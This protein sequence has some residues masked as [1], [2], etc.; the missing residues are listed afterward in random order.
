[1]S[2]FSPAAVAP[3]FSLRGELPIRRLTGALATLEVSPQGAHVTDWTIPGTPPVLFLSPRSVFQRGR[4]IRGG[5]PL[6]FPWFGPKAGDARAAQHGFARVRE[7]QL[8]AA[9]VQSDGACSV[10]M[11]LTD[12]EA[13]RAEWP[14]A[15]HARFA[16]T[17]G[18]ELRMTLEIRSAD[19]RDFTFEAA[20]HT[21]FAV[22]DVRRIRVRGLENTAYVDKVDGGARKPGESAPLAFT[23]ETDRVYLDTASACTIEDPGWDRRIVVAKSGSR[24]TVVWNPWKAKARAMA[25]LGDDA[26]TGMVCIET[27]NCGADARTLAPGG[28]HV[29]EAVIAVESSRAGE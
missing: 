17:A 24:S 7:W 10:A 16:A 12:D 11:S 18:R 15:F 19:S 1:M 21:Y 6:V 4:A 22:S 14:H 27:A 9:G 25:D 3:G 26:W 28:T 13:T 5:V 8:E 23:G 20:L 29:L 2:Q